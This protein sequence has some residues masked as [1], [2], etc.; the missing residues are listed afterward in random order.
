MYFTLAISSNF[1]IMVS[2]LMG[3]QVGQEREERAVPTVADPDGSNTL[4]ILKKE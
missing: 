2:Y 1:A 4:A 3:L